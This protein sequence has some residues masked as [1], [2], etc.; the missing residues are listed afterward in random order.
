MLNFFKKIFQNK[1]NK[2][3]E[4]FNPTPDQA[5]QN[6][7]LYAFK[8]SILPPAVASEYTAKTLE[9]WQYLASVRDGFTREKALR[10][11]ANF[12]SPTVLDTLIT[13]Q[14]DY[15][16]PVRNLAFDLLSQRVTPNMLEQLYPRLTSIY[17]LRWQSRS[18][19]V[20]VFRQILAVFFHPNNLSKTQKLL[21]TQQGKNI[22]A[23][24]Q[25]MVWSGDFSEQKLFNIAL[26]AQDIGINQQIWQN[27]M[28]LPLTE[29]IALLKIENGKLPIPNRA[30]YFR[31]LMTIVEKEPF[32]QWR[33]LAKDYLAI[34]TIAQTLTLLFYLN[35]NGFGLF[36]YANELVTTQG[37]QA[38]IA[39]ILKLIKKSGDTT[40]LEKLAQQ[41]PSWLAYHPFE[42]LKV[43]LLL[44][45][46]GDLSQN[47][48]SQ[49]P[50]RTF[51]Q[52]FIQQF[53][54]KWQVSTLSQYQQYAQY[55]NLKDNQYLWFTYA[56]PTWEQLLAITD[57]ISRHSTEELESVKTTLIPTLSHLA[58]KLS[59][60]TLYYVALT[61]E[62]KQQVKTIVMAHPTYFEKLLYQ[63]KFFKL[64]EK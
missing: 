3:T 44:M 52:R 13:R 32:A 28:R 64:I 29:K 47:L 33:A 23:L 48:L 54:H 15:V 30:F 50:N 57:F 36:D 5:P 21:Q 38:G 63:L 35:K 25:M 8:P 60:P 17:A 43:S 49:F 40:T 39:L 41:H 19:F 34:A 18:R 4:D 59:S 45:P 20:E 7:D 10:Q 14:N 26:Q 62:Q 37:E 9:E 31:L 55:L 42:W 27:L 11:L 58:E 2:N 22:R 56:L 6:L 61:E 24:Y 12:T 51:E 1:T 53:F 46:D 16:E